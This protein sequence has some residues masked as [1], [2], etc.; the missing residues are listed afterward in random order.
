MGP[1]GVFRR[2]NAASVLLRLNKYIWSKTGGHNI[3]REIKTSATSQTIWPF[4][5]TDRPKYPK[6]RCRR[7]S[8]TAHFTKW[9]AG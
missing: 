3:E 4:Y 5:V 9:P 8:E 7:R 6:I 1:K 2:E